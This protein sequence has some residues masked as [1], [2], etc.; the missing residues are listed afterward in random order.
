MNT[1]ISDKGT[2]V[3]LWWVTVTINGIETIGN[4]PVLSPEWVTDPGWESINI[5]HLDLLVLSTV[6]MQLWHTV[7]H[8]VL[9]L[10]LK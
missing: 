5:T 8:V 6:Q 9:M 1:P 2:I 10:M 3:L 4:I 7:S